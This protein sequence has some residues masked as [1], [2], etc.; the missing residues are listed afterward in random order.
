MVWGYLMKAETARKVKWNKENNGIKAKFIKF[1]SAEG[2]GM[3]NVHIIALTQ[4]L[5]GINETSFDN[6]LNDKNVYIGIFDK[7]NNELTH[8]KMFTG[9]EFKEWVK[10]GYE[11]KYVTRS[12]DERYIITF[13]ENII[14]DWK[15]G[16]QK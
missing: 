4:K 7:N 8:Y 9:Q 16:V 3:G 10:K 1:L 15:K 2:I 13:H 6:I 5:T 14:K 11:E 12:E